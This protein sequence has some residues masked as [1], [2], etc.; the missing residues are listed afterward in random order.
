MARER[1]ECNYGRRPGKFRGRDIDVICDAVG[2]GTYMR[3]SDADKPRQ[4]VLCFILLSL[5]Y[6]TGRADCEAL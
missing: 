4:S 1:M 2:R 5:D 3:L 6:A